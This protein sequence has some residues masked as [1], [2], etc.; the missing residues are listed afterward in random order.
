MALM[1]NSAAIV[2]RNNWTPSG[3]D[4]SK[5]LQLFLNA[6][7]DVQGVFAV[8]HDDDP[9]HHFPFA[10]EFRYA[11]TNVPAEVHSGDI[12]NVNRCSILDL[13]DDVFDVRGP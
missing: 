8:P 9:A 6:R 1:I 12:L 13:E 3:N 5:S 10:V 11:S 2:G 7:N 4:D